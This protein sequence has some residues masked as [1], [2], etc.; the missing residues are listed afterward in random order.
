[1]EPSDK[2]FEVKFEHQWGGEDTW[3]TKSKRWANKQNPVV[4]HLALGFLLWLWELWVDAK[5]ENEMRS[6]DRQAEEI[7]EQ[8]SQQEDDRFKFEETGT[9]GED[10]WSISKSFDNKDKD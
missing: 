7:K 8:W 9:F 10:G 2:R 1:M 4:K 3:Y 6:V 5:V